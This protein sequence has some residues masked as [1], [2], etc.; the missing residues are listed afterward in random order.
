MNNLIKNA[1]LVQRYIFFHFT[2]YPIPCLLLKGVNS[3]QSPLCLPWDMPFFL[4][5]SC[6]CIVKA[7]DWEKGSRRELN[8]F[9]ATLPLLPLLVIS[10]LYIRDTP[11]KLRRGDNESESF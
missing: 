7:L 5:S 10:L 6:L 11:S 4:S 2:M 1:R 3:L 8:Q 9:E